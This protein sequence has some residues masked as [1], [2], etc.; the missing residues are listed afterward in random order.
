MCLLRSN[1]SFHLV[2]SS[3][4]F[5]KVTSL[6]V[7][8]SICSNETYNYSCKP[9][10]DI[11]NYL[12]GKYFTL[13]FID[14]SFVLEDYESP[15]KKNYG[16]YLQVLVNT[17]FLMR[18]YISLM[19]VE[20][21]LDDSIWLNGEETFHYIQQDASQRLSEFK[22]KTLEDF[23]K[24]PLIVDLNFYPSF[25]KRIL[26]RKYQK[27]TELLSSLGGLASFLHF[28]GAFITNFFLHRKSLLLFVNKLYRL[29]EDE[30]NVSDPKAKDVEGN[31]NVD[32]NESSVRHFKSLNER[33]Q[34]DI[35]LCESTV[36]KKPIQ[37]GEEKAKKSMFLKVEFKDDVK[38]IENTNNFEQDKHNF[39]K[40]YWEILKKGKLKSIPLTIS[41]YEYIKYTLK[42]IFCQKKLTKKE[43]LIRSCEEVY[44][45]DLEIYFILKKIQEIDVLKE[46]LFVKTTT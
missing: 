40:E 20:L 9:I 2:S 38:I 12:K 42:T 22:Y 35:E 29:E 33:N 34:K 28:I 17:N 15:Q 43:N 6:S 44:N 4:W 14:S 16:N 18:S 45:N 3:F 13:S 41:V 25:T 26:K 31:R 32:L 27:L 21:V 10:S 5:G 39:Y 37:T 36:V 23:Q 24:D 11:L 7:S 8:L 1:H 46:I 30:S 19:E